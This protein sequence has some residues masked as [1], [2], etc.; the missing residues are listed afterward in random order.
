MDEHNS[1]LTADEDQGDNPLH[2]ASDRQD[3]NALQRDRDL[4]GSSSPGPNDIDYANSSRGSDP[5]REGLQ[6]G[7]GADEQ[8]A[9][10][11]LTDSLIPATLDSKKGPQNLDR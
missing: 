3:N 5:E 6:A 9:A 8:Y 4:G 11:P 10:D 7:S 2:Q 1:N